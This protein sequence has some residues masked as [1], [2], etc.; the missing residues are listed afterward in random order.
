MANDSEA[1][2][3]A[4]DAGKPCPVIRGEECKGCGRCI[5][6]CP[7][8]VLR[9]RVGVNSRGYKVA[10]YVG[11]GC[12]GCCLCF[13]TCP[14]PNTIEIHNPKRPNNAGGGAGAPR[15][16]GKGAVA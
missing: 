8:Q 11:A 2:S 1:K 15:D 12:I 4:A 10:E 3:S 16:N 6:A 5:A 9:F 7:K 13:Y 14:E